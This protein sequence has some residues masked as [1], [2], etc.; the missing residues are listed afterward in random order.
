MNLEIARISLESKTTVIFV[1]HSIAEAAF[2]SDRR[3][4]H[5]RA[6]CLAQGRRDDRPSKAARLELMASDRFGVYVTAA[7]NARRYARS[8]MSTQPSPKP[9]GRRI[10]GRKA[11]R[12]VRR[13]FRHCGRDCLCSHCGKQPSASGGA[14]V[15]LPPPS[16]VL[17]RLAI[18][19]SGVLDISSP[20]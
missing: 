7:K 13:L 17:G 19:I 9:K 20:R 14:A 2:L 3:L 11:L 6:S 4:R 16:D 15:V 5:D 8:L 10:S 18:G 1:T 12:S